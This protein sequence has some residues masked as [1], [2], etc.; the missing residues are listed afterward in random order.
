MKKIALLMIGFF[1]SFPGMA[2]WS[3]SYSAGYGTYDMSDMKT[4]L[5]E[6]YQSVLEVVPGLDL[7]ITDNFPGYVTHTLDIGYKFHQH[8][9]GVKGSYLSTAGKYSYADYSG[10]ISS[11]VSLDG[12]RGGA[13]YRYYFYQ[14]NLNAKQNISFWGEAAP[15]CIFSKVKINGVMTPQNEIVKMEN[16]SFDCFSF[17][18]LPQLGIKYTLF[19]NIDLRLSFGYEIDFSS[20]ISDIDSK[21]NWSG[22]RCSGGIGYVF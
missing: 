20:R 1:I 9:V 19:S 15:A 18:I 5:A 21:V 8:E 13:Y 4:Y 12:Y 14:I 3:V 22:F 17:S 6:H 7:V 2:Q 16:K 10:E 11:E